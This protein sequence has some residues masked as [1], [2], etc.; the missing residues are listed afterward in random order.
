MTG[1]LPYKN[2]DFSFQLIRTIHDEFSSL[3]MKAVKDTPDTEMDNL[4]S[5]ETESRVHAFERGE[6]KTV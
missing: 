3:T 6:L 1:V 2:T 5:K 4:W